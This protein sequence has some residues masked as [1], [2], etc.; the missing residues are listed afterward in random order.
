VP[1]LTR[2]PSDDATRG[3]LRLV[4][5]KGATKLI[6]EQRPTVNVEASNSGT[7]VGYRVRVDEGNP[8]RF[9]RFASCSLQK[10]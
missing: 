3:L 10:A 7:G 2:A 4:R 9:A 1:M 8:E 5:K 6:G